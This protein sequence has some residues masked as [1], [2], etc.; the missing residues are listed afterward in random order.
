MTGRLL[1]STENGETTSYFYDA[2]GRTLRV[3]CGAQ[4]TRSLYDSSGRLVQEI[5]PKQY[6]ASKDALPS[7][8]TYEDASAGT[9]YVYEANG[10]LISQTNH[11]DRPQRIPTTAPA[12]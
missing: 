12:T 2:A 8:N 4:T 6:E 9:R 11:M 10:N 5:G 1:S 3:Q 7:E